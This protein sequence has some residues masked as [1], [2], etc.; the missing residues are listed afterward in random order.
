LIGFDEA[1][2]ISQDEE[3]VLAAV[4]C[5]RQH[6]ERLAELLI[7][8]NLGPWKAKS[9]ELVSRT[10]PDERDRRVAALLDAIESEPVFWSAA[11]GYSD[12]SISHKAAALC[13]L[14]QK[15]ITTADEYAGDA[16][17]VPDGASDMYGTNQLYLRQQASQ[18]F[19]GSFQSVFGEVYISALP[20][21]DLTYPEV[22]SADYIAAYIR[23]QIQ[24]DDRI[25]ET[26]PDNV[27][28]FD[29]NWRE[30]QTA[31]V[32]FH[33]LRQA[34]GD[35]GVAERKRIVAWLRGRH[36]EGDDFNVSN[37]YESTVRSMLSSER[38]QE[39]LLEM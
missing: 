11:V 3:F 32:P 18:R 6:S 27:A 24:N 2:N 28:R 20:R 26:L 7:D 29:Y 1:G 33:R 22:T 25:P 34:T 35:Y 10:S 23:S 12:I 16:V 9:R 36:P 21:A 37:R 39:Y 38:V 15:T 17:V 30:P 4:R 8:C 14:A 19:G 13:V 5:P 31:P